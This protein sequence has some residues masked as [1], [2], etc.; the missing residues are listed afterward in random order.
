MPDIL[1]RFDMRNP[2]FGADREALYRAAI[3]MA[4]W[5]DEQG[6]YGVQFSEHHASEDGYLPSPLVLAAAIAA[7][8]QR[9]RL[10]IAL[11]LLPLNNPLKVAEDLAVLDVISGGRVEVVF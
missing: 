8:T 2:A 10:R 5:A 7:R 1:L 4:V 3:E 6:L 9:L 11:I